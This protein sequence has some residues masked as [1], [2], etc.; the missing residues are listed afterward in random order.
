MKF[1]KSSK[2]YHSSATADLYKTFQKLDHEILTRLHSY[3]PESVFPFTKIKVILWR[4]M[5]FKFRFVSLCYKCRNIWILFLRKW[6]KANKK[7]NILLKVENVF[8][9]SSKI[10]FF[11]KLPDSGIIYSPEILLKRLL[12]RY[13]QIDSDKDVHTLNYFSG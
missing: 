13:L 4:K 9:L 3:S 12:Q 8:N 11:F 10:R 1:N 2:I 7:E 6:Y 5:L